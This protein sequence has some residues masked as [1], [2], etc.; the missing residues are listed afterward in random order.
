MSAADAGRGSTNPGGKSRRERAEVLARLRRRYEKSLALYLGEGGEAALNDAYQIG[1]EGFT[2]GIGLVRLSDIHNEAVAKALERTCSPSEAAEVHR[3]AALFLQEVMS[4]FEMAMNLA[5]TITAL[6]NMYEQR[7]RLEAMEELDALKDKFLG[8]ISHELR[9]PI[10]AIL[11]FGSLLEDGVAGSLNEK[12]RE[13]V[14]KLLEG[15]DRLLYLVNDL[16][17]MTRIQAGKLRLSPRRI[18]FSD[19]VAS[20]V[21]GLEPLGRAK[22]LALTFRVG[23]SLPPICGD[24]QRLAQVLTNLVS[25]AIKFTPEGGAIEVRAFLDGDHLRC[26][27]QDSGIGISEE[28]Q[29]NLFKPFS[30]VGNS[31]AG[32]RETGTGL[33]LAIACALVEAHGGAIGVRSE[34]GK[35]SLFWFTIPLEGNPDSP[36]CE[37]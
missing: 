18:D 22:R 30:Q 2:D 19:V 37:P 6:R 11:G 3:K 28:D 32:A 10:H 25:N 8:I 24:E 13:Y 23:D 33:G 29:S 15:A 20:T 12:Q 1:R 4:P 27:V 5:E 16:L 7:A 36:T 31:Q 14:H 17:D 34:P 26:E 21:G 35:G 9:T